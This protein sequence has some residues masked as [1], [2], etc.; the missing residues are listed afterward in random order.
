MSRTNRRGQR[1]RNAQRYQDLGVIWPDR[2]G[3]QSRWTGEFIPYWVERDNDTFT[4]EQY[5][6]DE[7]RKYHQ[8]K[9]QCG[10][11]RYARKA[12]L[13]IQTRAHKRSV[14]LAVKTGDYDVVLAGLSKM[15]MLND[16]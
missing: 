10:I 11:A 13:A 4:Y 12:D 6:A 14:R 15:N 8:D 2:A 3:F 9:R 16:G 1:S 7:I 5:V